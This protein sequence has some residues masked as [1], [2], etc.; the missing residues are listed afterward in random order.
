MIRVGTLKMRVE[1]DFWFAYYALPEARMTEWVCLGSIAMSCCANE[2]VKTAFFLLMRE[3][4]GDIIERATGI[5]P[6]W[7]NA[8]VPGPEH[9]RTQR[10]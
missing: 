2:A 4:V 3:A 9:E 5:R 6:V 7:P 8:P 1:G 10:G